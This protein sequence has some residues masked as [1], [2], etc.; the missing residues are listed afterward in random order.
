MPHEALN[1]SDIVLGPSEDGGYY[2]SLCIIPHD[3][4]TG[5]S[6]EHIPSREKEQSR[7][8]DQLGSQV[9]LLKH[10]LM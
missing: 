5:I 1:E 9:R 6:D 4:F 3:V 8:L 10:Y 2:L 7:L